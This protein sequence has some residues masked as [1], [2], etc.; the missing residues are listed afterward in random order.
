M[1]ILSIMS[2]TG[3]GSYVIVDKIIA[4]NKTSTS[5]KFTNLQIVEEELRYIAYNYRYMQEA[6]SAGW[7]NRPDM[8]C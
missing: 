7:C 1:S 3:T 4:Q 8:V 5:Q 2:I 6:F